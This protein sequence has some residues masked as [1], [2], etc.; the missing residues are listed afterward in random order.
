MDKKEKRPTVLFFDSGVGGFSVYC[1]AKRLLP[2][3]HYLYCFDNAGFPY[4][5]REEESIIHRT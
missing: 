4:S 5:E 1:E 3:W 2:N